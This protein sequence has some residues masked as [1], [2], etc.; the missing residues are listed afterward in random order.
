MSTLTARLPIQIKKSW[1]A[2]LYATRNGVAVFHAGC[3]AALHILYSPLTGL[4]NLASFGPVC[5]QL[6]ILWQ[7]QGTDLSSSRGLQA[8]HGSRDL[9]ETK[10]I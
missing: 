5:K 1:S 6:F 9:W 2:W 7:K 10:L 8:S 3:E 4:V